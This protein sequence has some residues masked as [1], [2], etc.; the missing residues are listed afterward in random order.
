MEPQ[1]TIK[2]AL[3]E[4][5][6]RDFEVRSHPWRRA[7]ENFEC[8]GEEKVTSKKGWKKIGDFDL[9]WRNPFFPC[10]LNMYFILFL[11][12][13]FYFLIKALENK[14]DRSQFNHIIKLL[15]KLTKA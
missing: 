14:F 6:E 12:I 8:Y 7:M 2:H 15:V 3:L 10:Y 11:L 13:L 5:D 9:R 4:R 1:S